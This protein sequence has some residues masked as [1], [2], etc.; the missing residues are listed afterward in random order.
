MLWGAEAGSMLGD[1][2][3]MLVLPLYVTTL[4]SSS[5]AVTWVYAAENIPIVLIGLFG[6]LWI[7][8]FRSKPVMIATDLVRAGVYGTLAVLAFQQV[9]AVWVVWLASFSVGM[10]T[11]AFSAALWTLIPSLVR[12][13]DL[14]RANARMD[15][16]ARA[17]VL[18]G[19]L[20]GG[21]IVV[22]GGYHWAFA[23]NAATFLISAVGVAYAGAG[24]AGV[25]LEKDQRGWGEM[26]RGV[27]ILWD[28]KIL[29]ATTGAAA[30][31]SVIVGVLESAFVLIGMHVLET[32]DPARLG[33]LG[34]AMGVAMT[35]GAAAA[36]RLVPRLGEVSA[37]CG[38]TLALAVGVAGVSLITSP[39]AA[40]A[41]FM[42]GMFFIPIIS[43]GV[44]GLRQRRAPGG[45]LGR[46]NAASR[47]IIWAALPLTALV[48]GAAIDAWSEAAVLQIA[49]VIAGAGAAWAWWW[50]RK[51]PNA[52]TAE[53]M[54]SRQ[55]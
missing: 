21:V 43:V 29:R 44:V 36:G 12:S 30:A 54:E 53:T 23:A 24:T 6:G 13:K 48:A 42:A 45:T 14:D 28:D 2:I 15:L 11:A 37:V 20:L 5:T 39:W 51:R 41:A 33:V 9:A 38:G 50:V 40:G 1:Q 10:A 55:S 25:K 19:P 34:V 35:A 18:T 17:S 31:A 47:A 22:G 49:A 16:A 52:G 46:V 4:T 27:R 3:A 26:L 7:D 8:R 32:T